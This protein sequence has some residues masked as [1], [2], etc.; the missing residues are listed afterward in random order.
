MVRLRDALELTGVPHLTTLCQAAKRL[1]T[2]PMTDRL[3][4]AT[5]VLC[6]EAKVLKKQFTLAAIDSTGLETRHVS[7]YFIKRCK[8]HKGQLKH[9]YPKLSA[10]CDTAT[11]LILG[12][13]IDRGPKPDYVEDEQTLCE[14]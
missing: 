14:A 3:F 2:K 7:S 10:I 5:L 11:H 13:V 9:R 1:L 6:R 4:A 8:T 12:N